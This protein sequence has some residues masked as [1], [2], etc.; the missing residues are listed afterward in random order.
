MVQGMNDLYLELA[1]FT[2]PAASYGKAR[3]VMPAQPV[4]F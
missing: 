4:R 2:E 3:Q 1:G